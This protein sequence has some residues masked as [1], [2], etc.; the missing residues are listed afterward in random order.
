M[1][2]RGAEQPA[3][4]GPVQPGGGH[5]PG[6][7]RAQDT[8][9]CRILSSDAATQADREAM[10]RTPAALLWGV[11]GP[12]CQCGQ[13]NQL[14]Q[15]GKGGDYISRVSDCQSSLGATTKGSSGVGHSQFTV[16]QT[17]KDLAIL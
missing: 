7:L 11:I 12:T 10:G 8:H 3:V 9:H 15:K 16:H 1:S 17:L 2:V 6:H 14:C 4:R 13:H 5:L